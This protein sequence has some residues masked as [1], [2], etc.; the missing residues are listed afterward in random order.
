MHV[1]MNVVVVALDFDRD[2]VYLAVADAAFGGDCFRQGAYFSRWAAQKQGFQAVIVVEVDVHAG[3]DQVM[4]VVLQIGEA[5]GQAAFVMVVDVGQ[6]GDAVWRVFMF[7]PV[8]F[9]FSPQ[10]VAHGFRAVGIAA[11][12][13]QGVEFQRERFIEGD[14]EAF[15]VLSR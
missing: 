2:Q 13:E 8:C 9:E 11:I 7:Q 15:H 3:D 14:G 1:M 6:I 5:F 4:R 12:A 10:H